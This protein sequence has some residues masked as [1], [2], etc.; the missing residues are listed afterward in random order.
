MGNESTWAHDGQPCNI[1]VTS[2]PTHLSIVRPSQP[3][4]VDIA[5][6]IC[7]SGRHRCL[8]GDSWSLDCFLGIL[9][10]FFLRD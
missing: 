9:L 10:D 5:V 8:W 3:P 7:L 6:A 4:L 1:G 2:G